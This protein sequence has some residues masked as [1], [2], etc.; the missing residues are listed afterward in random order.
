MDPHDIT[1]PFDTVTFR[2]EDEPPQGPP[3]K[4][5]WVPYILQTIGLLAA[6]IVYAMSQ[7]HRITVIEETLRSTRQIM[8]Q[9]QDTEKLLVDQLHNQQQSLQQLITL[10]DFVHGMSADEAEGYYRAKQRQRAQQQVLG[11]R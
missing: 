8:E 7:E 5:D 6:G 11:K 2:H 9:Q 3:V 10:E 1:A 4:R